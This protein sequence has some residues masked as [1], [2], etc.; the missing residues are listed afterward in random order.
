MGFFGFWRIAGS[1]SGTGVSSEVV[2]TGVGSCRVDI[3]VAGCWIRVHGGRLLGCNRAAGGVGEERNPQQSPTPPNGESKAWSGHLIPVWVVRRSL[4]P[5]AG[6]RWL[7]PHPKPSSSN[8]IQL[9]WPSGQRHISHAHAHTHSL[10]SPA[11]STQ[12]S[13]QASGR[14]TSPLGPT[15]PCPSFRLTHPSTHLA[16]RPYGSAAA[17][18]RAKE[19]EDTPAPDV[20]DARS[21]AQGPSSLALP[22]TPPAPSSSSSQ[23][24]NGAS[25][26]PQRSEAERS[27][28]TSYPDDFVVGRNT[29]RTQSL[30]SSPIDHS[31]PA[32]APSSSSSLP[33]SQPTPT[34][35]ST[36]PD[37]DYLQLRHIS[38]LKKEH[39]RIRR[40]LEALG[41]QM[42]T[43]TSSA[44]TTTAFAEGRRHGTDRSGSIGTPAALPQTHSPRSD[45]TPNK[46]SSTSSSQAGPSK[47]FSSLSQPRL[48]P[49]STPHPPPPPSPPPARS[50]SSD[51]RFPTTT[52]P[53]PSLTSSHERPSS[54]PA[55]DLARPSSQP[56]NP[57]PP[58]LAQAQVKKKLS[59]P[60][61]TF[62]LLSK[63][64]ELLGAY[65]SGGGV[66]PVGGASDV[67][68]EVE[69]G[70][71][72]G[73]EEVLIR[74][75][76]RG[77]VMREGTGVVGPGQ[78]R[79]DAGQATVPTHLTDLPP[80]KTDDSS[81]H[82]NAVGGSQGHK[83]FWRAIRWI[84]ENGAGV[85]GTCPQVFWDVV[86]R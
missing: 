24:S 38:T 1:D 78:G 81:I 65:L 86:L 15:V 29:H 60:D 9:A 44:R 52:T 56:P 72:N 59:Q 2:G 5:R 34:S 7:E 50:I 21:T 25:E 23:P 70:Q 79:T 20:Q 64:Q 3:A 6:G 57:D 71:A 45:S 51:L 84:E 53:R 48:P 67:G 42:P 37:R 68:S 66:R 43:E 73:R 63:V 69:S 17:L 75:K 83:G 12:V 14:H 31:R 46:D 22:S 33:P 35:Q 18:S 85:T 16:G 61:P 41:V 4:R 36:L 80:R 28:S 77:T 54:V 39:T 19:V 30:I 32:S 8:D 13:S 82:V 47:P 55:D 11:D 26:V 74:L 40:K 62:E 27:D 49:P 58:V 76:D 10:A